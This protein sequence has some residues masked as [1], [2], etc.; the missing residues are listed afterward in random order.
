M[1]NYNP[2]SNLFNF[3]FCWANHCTGCSALNSLPSNCRLSNTSYFRLLW[4]AHSQI[5]FDVSTSF[6]FSLYG[7]SYI[8]K[9]TKLTI[10]SRDIENAGQN[11][12]MRALLSVIIG[13]FLSI[14]SRINFLCGSLIVLTAISY[15]NDLKRIFCRK[16]IISWKN[17][18]IHNSVFFLKIEKVEKKI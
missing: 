11:L 7:S 13:Q 15:R 16:L 18:N 10:S 9:N 2:L 5:I 1:I 3:Y 8:L 4:F 17:F 12:V 6:V 14:N